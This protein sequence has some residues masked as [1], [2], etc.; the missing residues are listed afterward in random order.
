MEAGAPHA[1]LSRPP[2]PHPRRGRPQERPHRHRHALASSA[3]RCAS[4]WPRAFR[5]SRP[6]SCTCKSI[7]HE[8]LWFLRGDTNVALPQGATASRI[9]DEWADD[10]GDLGPV[11]GKQWRSWPTP[12]GGTVDQIAWVVDEIRTQPRFAPP[13]RLGLEPG[14]P[15]PDGAG[16]LPLPVPVLRRRRAALLPALP[17]LGRRL[18]RRAVQHRLLRAAHP[19]GGAGDGPRSRAISCTRF[20]DAHLY[21]NHLEQ[22]RLQLAR[23]PRPLPRLRAQPGGALALRLPLRGLRDR[24]LRPAPGDQGAGRRLTPAASGAQLRYAAL[25]ERDDFSRVVI[26]L[27]LFV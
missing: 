23:E 18:P 3:T 17:A 24:G 8:L 7:V 15:R 1:R 16:A 21:L 9:W 2:A 12:D 4:T 20:G 10:D 6:R 19:H 27:Y 25:L 26:P 22:A 14:R 5:W 13:H 11:Y